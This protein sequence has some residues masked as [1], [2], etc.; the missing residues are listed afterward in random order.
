MLHIELL[1]TS[2]GLWD[3][4]R[5]ITSRALA[6]ESDVWLIDH[7]WVF[8]PR[9]A[10]VL[11]SNMFVGLSFLFTGSLFSL[12]ILGSSFSFACTSQSNRWNDWD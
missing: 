7:A 6:A 4:R 5:V 1:Q 11:K 3:R 2:E 10:R 12:I 9:Y 8:D